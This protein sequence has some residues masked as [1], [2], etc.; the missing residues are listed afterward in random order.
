MMSNSV[1]D[2]MNSFY[3][4]LKILK[5]QIKLY[6]FLM[7]TVIF[8]NHECICITNKLNLAGWQMFVMSTLNINSLG[9]FKE[10]ITINTLVM[11]K[12]KS[13]R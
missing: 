11:H 2:K 4:F 9:I 10:Y 6:G 7:S 1:T 8:L 3:I 12:M 13:L 5:W